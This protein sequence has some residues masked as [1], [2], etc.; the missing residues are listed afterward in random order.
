[1]DSGTAV[2]TLRTRLEETLRP[3]LATAKQVALVD[4][5]NTA[6]VGDSAIYLG[7]LACLETLSVPFPG[8]VCDLRTYDR[9]ELARRIGPAGV[10]LLA[11][12]GSFGDVWRAPQELREE[13]VRSFPANPIIQLPQTIHFDRADALH[14]ARTALNDH[15]NLTVLARDHLSLEIAANEFRARSL[16]CPD[17]AF[18][19]GSLPRPVA[20]SRPILWLMRTDK[21]TR[22]DTRPT[23]RNAVDWLHEPPMVLRTLSYRL[24]GAARR[25]LIR[26]LARP[27]LTRLYSPLAR[28]RL[29]RGLEMLASAEVVVTDRMHGHILCLLLGIPHVLLDN[30]YGKL[31]SFHE[32]WTTDVAD[33]DWADSPDDALVK[34]TELAARRGLRVIPDEQRA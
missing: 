27:L 7:A 32:T 18:A 1:M 17:M 12:G 25:P 21:E 16:L 29:R 4:F 15:P 14:R 10:I 6:N 30:S 33:V 23:D 9:A 2:A 28:Q 20:P 13:I 24:M 3:L 34:A 19:L 31:S 5:P 11:G 22:P 8:F 26:R